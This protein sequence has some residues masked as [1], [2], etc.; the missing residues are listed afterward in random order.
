MTWSFLG[1]R[2]DRGPERP[3]T[4]AVAPGWLLLLVVA[5]VVS[6]PPERLSEASVLL[7]RASVTGR[8]LKTRGSGSKVGIGGKG[9]RENTATQTGSASPGLA[10][11]AGLM[12]VTVCLAMT[13]K[14]SISSSR[15][16]N[17]CVS[18]EKTDCQRFSFAEATKLALAHQ[19]A[20]YCCHTKQKRGSVI[21]YVKN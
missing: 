16:A 12:S 17:N 9:G 3:P 4:S 6:S 1:V 19:V 14:R 10:A 15:S 18:E 13:S 21:I 20:A 2:T 8:E 5:A 7:P 11:A